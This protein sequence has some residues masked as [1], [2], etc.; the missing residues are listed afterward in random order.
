MKVTD[1]GGLLEEDIEVIY[2]KCEDAK[3]FMFDTSLQKTPGMM[4]AFYW[5]FDNIKAQ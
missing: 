5:F 3:K 1:G 4:M 2:I